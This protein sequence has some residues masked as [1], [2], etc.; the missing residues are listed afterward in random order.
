MTNSFAR[1]QAVGRSDRT[2]A[3]AAIS[4]PTKQLTRLAVLAK[5]E[6]EILLDEF[7]LAWLTLGRM[8]SG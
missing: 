8:A 2:V 4:A 6:R 1:T 3:R 7:G 5:F